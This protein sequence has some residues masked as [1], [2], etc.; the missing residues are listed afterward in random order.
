MT[1]ISTKFLLGFGIFF[2]VFGTIALISSPEEFDDKSA[3]FFALVLFGYLPLYFGIK[4]YIKEKKTFKVNQKNIRLRAI[5]D[6]VKQ[7]DNR[8]D[9]LKASIVLN[10]SQSE[11]QEVLDSLT[12][13]GH[14]T[15]EINEKGL[16]FYD[17]NN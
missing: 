15:M 1:K 13:S 11:A 2:G 8:I 16:I 3:T 5:F 6:Y 17:F 14:C 4:R 9:T 10:I 7:N 12:K